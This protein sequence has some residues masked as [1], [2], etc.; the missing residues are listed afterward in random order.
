[1]FLLY[2]AV[3]LLAGCGGGGGSSTGR[4]TTEQASDGR[5]LTGRGFTFRA[6]KDWAATIASRAAIAKQDEVT[7]VSVTVLPLV[8]PYRPSLFPRV[9]GEL[10]RVTGALA[11]RLKGPVTERKTI[12]VAGG[13]V[14]QYQIVHGE[15]VD[16][17][18]FVFRGKQ[19]FL[20][21]CRWRKA[22]G[23]PAACGQLVSSFSFR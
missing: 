18:T 4:G 11:A 14:R 13:R 23:E 10:D 6:P 2:A 20:L 15:L 7:L 19:E 21:T 1:M 12:I 3:A 8:K 9:I 22:D 17:L 16:R 5:L